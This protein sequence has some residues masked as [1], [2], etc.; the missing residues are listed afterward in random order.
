MCFFFFLFGLKCEFGDW[1]NQC[2]FSTAL[3]WEYFSHFLLKCHNTKQ[4]RWIHLVLRKDLVILLQSFSGNWHLNYVFWVQFLCMRPCL[5]VTCE[6]LKSAEFEYINS[7]D[8]SAVNSIERKIGTS[9]PS[10]RACGNNRFL[11]LTNF[12]LF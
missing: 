6:S 8:A 9:L 3:M 4:E 2:L 12:L 1:F 10:L 5:L 11:L 7:H